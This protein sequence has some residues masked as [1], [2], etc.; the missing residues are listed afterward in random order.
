MVRDSSSLFD[1]FIFEDGSL[2]MMVGAKVYI[3]QIEANLV[4][5]VC[6]IPMLLGSSI[7]CVIVVSY[8]LSSVP[9]KST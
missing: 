5:E 4:I 3:C 9:L 7:E 1:P 2:L 8:S 6:S